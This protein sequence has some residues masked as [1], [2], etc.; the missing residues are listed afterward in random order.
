MMQ[1]QQQ[2]QQQQQMMMRQ[3]QMAQQ[4]AMA[5]QNTQQKQ[6]VIDSD[7]GNILDNIK[8]EA[9]NIM[10]VVFLCILLNID[11]VDS[12]FRCQSWFMNESGALNMQAVVLKSLLIGVIF[13][14]VKTYLL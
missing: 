7:P 1:Q 11:Q 4:Q 6:N 8:L 9:K 12:I 2:Q 13:Y 5:N 14:L 10:V 3:Q